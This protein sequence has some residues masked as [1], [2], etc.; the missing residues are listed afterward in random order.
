MVSVSTTYEG[1]ETKTV[2]GASEKYHCS[3]DIGVN[4]KRGEFT[5]WIT[6]FTTQSRVIIRSGLLGSQP[7]ATLILEGPVES[8]AGKPITNMPTQ[9]YLKCLPT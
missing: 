2:D 8:E 5:K 4:I 1:N 7:S 9:K 3:L 6:G